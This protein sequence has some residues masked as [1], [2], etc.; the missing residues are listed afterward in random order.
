MF[1][2]DILKN[3]KNEITKITYFNFKTFQLYINFS[4]IIFL[5]YILLTLW[6]YKYIWKVFSF[7]LLYY[8]FVYN[9]IWLFLWFVIIIIWLINSY[10]VKYIK[11]KKNE[12]LVQTIDKIQF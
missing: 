8:L 2:S 7:D 10:E 6:N 5:W 11:D 4:L 1:K 3:K 9:Y 12:R